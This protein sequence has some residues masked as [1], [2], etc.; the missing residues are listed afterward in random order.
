[1]TRREVIERAIEGKINWIQAADILD[2]TPRHLRRLRH[3]Y[4]RLGD[5]GLVDGRRGYP[6]PRRI[7][8]TVIDEICRLKRDLYPDFSI[9][10]FH[11]FATERHGIQASYTYTK[12]IL[13]MH[14][15]AEKAKG[16]GKYRRK[17]DRRPMA[18]MLL[19]LDASTH[20]WIPGIP[21]QDLV[22]MLDD[23]DGRI[24]FA[25]FFGQ[26]STQ[27]SLI[28]IRHVLRRFG[29]FSEL[30]TDRGSHFCHTSK[31]GEGPDEEQTGQVTR[32]LR[33]LGIRHILA[34]SPEARGRSERAFGTLQGR[35]PQ[36]LRAARIGTYEGAN[37]YLDQTFIADFNQRF[38]VTTTEPG[39][40][41][42]PLKGIDL[43]L[44]LTVQHERIVRNDNTVVFG[45][46]ELQLPK[47]S[48]RMHFSRCP[49]IVHQFL[50]G[51]TLGVSFQGKLIAKFDSLGTKSRVAA[52]MTVA[53]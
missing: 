42:T 40:A 39:S 8:P 43:D 29:R 1:M 50:D 35:L 19:H 37:E 45:K 32:V 44:L 25:R 31:A 38:T 5:P 6:R 11:E 30:Y 14:G 26:E 51:K 20:E 3:R 16:R 10:H 52:K 49:V 13:Q 24:L 48:Q 15:L 47:T 21:M 41:F 9:R 2:L 22:V 46:L 28:A 36:E 53:A 33:A 4:E 34:R 27:T 12:D 18:G 23:G 7:S 17:R